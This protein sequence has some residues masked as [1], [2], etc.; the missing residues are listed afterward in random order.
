LLLVHGDTDEI[1]PVEQAYK[2]YQKAKEP[3]ELA[4][5]PGARHKLRLEEKAMATVLDWL[6]AMR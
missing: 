3:K 4:I 5:I 2:L 6:R 1:V